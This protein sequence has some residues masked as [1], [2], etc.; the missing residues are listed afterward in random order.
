[1]VVFCRLLPHPLHD[2]DEAPRHLAL[3]DH[4]AEPVEPLCAWL[5]GR[6]WTLHRADSLDESA[7]LLRRSD[8]Q[9]ALVY[10]LTL[11]R[12]GLEW[13]TLAPLLSPARPLPWLLMP[14]EE[15]SPTA[16]ARL[17]HGRGA[18]ADWARPSDGHAETE[19]RLRN[20]LR[21]E[22]LLA[23]SRAELRR[24]EDQL[25]TDHKT[26]LAN[27]R[28]FRSR[29]RQEFERAQRHHVPV[30]LILL[31]VDRFKAFNDEH[32]YEFGD[33]ALRAIGDA[34][35]ESVRSIDIPAR[36]GGDEF[37]VIL[38]S[39]TLAESLA[40]ARRIRQA[41][42]A[43]GLEHDGGREPLRVSQGVAGYDGHG[44][45]D[46]Q[47]FFLN[48]NEA[49]KAAKRAGDGSVRFWDVHLRA[50]SGAERVPD[51]E[52]ESGGAEAEGGGSPPA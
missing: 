41:V 27:D 18:V 7:D 26:G 37:A 8:L 3:L 33:Q 10:P 25:I 50:V 24:L 14:W 31:D 12:E 52:R 1:M 6:G 48:A 45:G 20:L 36:I 17:L 11:L 13:S 29:L 38:P 47:R 32:S 51:A 2:L 42:A 46:F 5:E 28:H 35:R 15:A 21:M 9:A 49:L 22:A 23:A 34:L 44:V 40:V 4:R 43:A 39:T 30:G 16:I 19:A